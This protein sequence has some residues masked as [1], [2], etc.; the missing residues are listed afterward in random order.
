MPLSVCNTLVCP[1]DTARACA[2][3]VSNHMNASLF[4]PGLNRFT[5]LNTPLYQAPYPGYR[6]QVV[7]SPRTRLHC[8]AGSS[9][10]TG[11]GNSS[12][13]PRRRR[14]ATTRRTT[15]VVPHQ[16]S[17][18]NLHTSTVAHRSKRGSPART[19]SQP[20]AAQEHRS[21]QQTQPAAGQQS[22]STAEQSQQVAAKEPSP[23]APSAAQAA[24]RPRKKRASSPAQWHEEAEPPHICYDLNSAVGSYSDLNRCSV[25]L[26]EQETAGANSTDGSSRRSSGST[27]SSQKPAPSSSSSNGSHSGNG[28]GADRHDADAVRGL[29][30]GATVRFSDSAALRLR[31]RAMVVW[32]EV[33]PDGALGG[34]RRMSMRCVMFRPG[35]GTA[36]CR[37]A[38]GLAETSF[39]LHDMLCAVGHRQCMI[40]LR[41]LVTAS[42]HCLCLSIA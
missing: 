35:Q 13:E 31:R 11:P 19:T 26:D 8:S 21:A 6:P 25:H 2:V 40:G 20:A 22:T 24:S 29:V 23:A 4:G 16:Q 39:Q 30:Y 32:E 9:R 1:Y 36:A 38:L 5:G 10:P 42:S 18:E 27:T 14:R 34:M 12:S 3:A 15:S 41:I 33:R 28:T 7:N 37:E 17:P